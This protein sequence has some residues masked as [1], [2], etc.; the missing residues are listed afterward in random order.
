[1]KNE[2][3]ARSIPL[4]ALASHLRQNRASIEPGWR[5]IFFP[6]TRKSINWQETGLAR[7]Q[8][9]LNETANALSID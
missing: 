7:G 6:R 5:K 8:L 9:E 1:V 4:V 3:L 2:R